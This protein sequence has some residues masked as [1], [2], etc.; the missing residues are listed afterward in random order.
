M[1]YLGLDKSVSL[2]GTVTLGLKAAKT[3]N[4]PL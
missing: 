1:E 4:T 3:E 2:F